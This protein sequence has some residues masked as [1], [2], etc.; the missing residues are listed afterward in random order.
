[1]LQITYEC[2]NIPY[3]H[4][5]TTDTL[6]PLAYQFLL[7]WPP[8]YGTHRYNHNIIILSVFLHI[9]MYHFVSMKL[10]LTTLDMTTTLLASLSG[11]NTT[12][13]DVEKRLSA[14]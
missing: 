1:M 6:E 5:S 4:S 12:K 11:I 7:P 13:H 8:C 3:K 10:H 14:S 2:V 9:Y